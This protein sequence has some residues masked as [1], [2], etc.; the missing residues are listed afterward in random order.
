MSEKKNIPDKKKGTAGS[1]FHEEE[2]STGAASILFSWTKA[3][4]LAM[5]FVVLLLTF[6]FR[7]VTVNGDS[8][9]NTLRSGDRLIIT[10]F[11]TNIMYTP[12][13]GDIVVAADDQKYNDLIVKRVIATPGQHLTINYENGEVSVDGVIL[14]EPYIKGK[15]VRLK[16]LQEIPE[17]IPEG[18][19]FVMG[20]NREFS[21]D[22]RSKRIGLIPV[23]NILGKAEAR[24]YPFGSIGLI[25][26]R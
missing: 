13:N 25:T 5:I 15:T 3:F 12:E 10:N 4:I 19:V 11:L 24:I 23:E 8:M 20:D 26:D 14:D 18:Y 1:V 16:D 2:V 22:S 6:V 7:Q 17:I 21:L 9:N